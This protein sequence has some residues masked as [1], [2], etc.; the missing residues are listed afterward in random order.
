MLHGC[1]NEPVPDQNHFL[2]ELA[3]S[4]VLGADLV[5]HVEELLQGLA[6]RRHDEADNVHQK[7]GHRVAIEHDCQDALHCLLLC[8]IAALFKLCSEV[9]KR[10][11]IGCVVLMHQTVGIVQESRHGGC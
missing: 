2:L 9:L 8:F 1:S 10:W 4:I 7:L 11:L 3:S 6:L 5:V